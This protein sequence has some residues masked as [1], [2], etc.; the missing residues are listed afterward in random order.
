MQTVGAKILLD[1]RLAEMRQIIGLLGSEIRIFEPGRDDLD[2]CGNC[3]E[4]LRLAKRLETTQKEDFRGTEKNGRTKL[5]DFSCR[6]FDD[7]GRLLS[8]SI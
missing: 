6:C 3:C 2:D 7:L 4:L 5:A 8:H 1:R